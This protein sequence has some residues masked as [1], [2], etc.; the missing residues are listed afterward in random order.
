MLT[1]SGGV[2]FLPTEVCGRCRMASVAS[3]LWEDLHEVRGS[4]GD[5]TT[6][7]ASRGCREAG[8]ELGE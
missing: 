1:A 5:L 7:R 2:A 4:L 3:L 6:S 8:I